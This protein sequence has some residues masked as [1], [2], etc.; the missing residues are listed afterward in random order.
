M[1]IGG[2]KIRIWHIAFFVIALIGFAI[3]RAPASLIV[4]SREDGL[5]Y[6]RAEGTIWDGRFVDARLNGVDAGTISYKV[7]FIK[8]VRG[9]VYV[10]FDMAGG[11]LTGEGLN[12]RADWR[13]DRR[14]IAPNLTLEGAQLGEGLTLAGA[15]QIRGLDLYFSD[16]ACVTASGTLRSDV[17]SRS[18]AAL[19]WRGPQLN[20]E[21]SCRDSAAQL[22]LLGATGEGD[23]IQ[24]FI[25]LTPTGEG[26][27]RAFVSTQQPVLRTVLTQRGFAPLGEG[28]NI[29]LSRNFR[30]LPM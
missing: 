8:L 28:P 2:F 16:G 5:A 23:T 26:L 7:S 10:D 13:G 22:T 3:A 15:T 19:N 6:S 9:M 11:A 18:A 12:F 25:E 29:S 1:S 27:W 4:P 24:S 30:W 20:G 17:L 21:A 14:L